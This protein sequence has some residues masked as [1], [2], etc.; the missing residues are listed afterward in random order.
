MSA[1]WTKKKLMLN[2][3]QV[4]IVA[5]VIVEVGIELNNIMGHPASG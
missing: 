3:T 2:S 5:E 4:E 1:G